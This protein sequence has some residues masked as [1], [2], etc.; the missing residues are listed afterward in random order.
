M[1]PLVLEHV[2]KTKQP[3]PWVGNPFPT[4]Q[5]S[6]QPTSCFSNAESPT[7]A[8]ADESHPPPLG[9]DVRETRDGHLPRDGV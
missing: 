1:L 9:T 5:R 8:S 6:T 3:N 7:D 4:L 2:L